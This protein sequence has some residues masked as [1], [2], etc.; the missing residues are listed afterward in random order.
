VVVAADDPV[1][2]SATA[3]IYP[4]LSGITDSACEQCPDQVKLTSEVFLHQL[5]NNFLLQKDGFPFT[6]ELG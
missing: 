5:P 3:K 4:P 1:V 2:W 6:Q